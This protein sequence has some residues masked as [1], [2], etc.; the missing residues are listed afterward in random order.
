MFNYYI[1]KYNIDTIISYNYRDI[2]YDFLY[3]QLNFKFIK[4]TQPNCYWI[5]NNTNIKSDINYNTV[6]LYEHKLMKDNETHIECMHRL[7]AKRIYDSGYKMYAWN[8]Y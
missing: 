7:K 4:N 8:R 3:K 2:C 6:Y 5:E 1:N